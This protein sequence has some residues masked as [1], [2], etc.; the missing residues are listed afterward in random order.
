[1]ALIGTLVSFANIFLTTGMGTGVSVSSGVFSLVGDI[2]TRSE[3]YAVRV[4]DVMDEG[5]RDDL[6]K[7]GGIDAG[8]L[9]AESDERE[10]S[11]PRTA[12]H[13]NL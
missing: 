1:L 13:G 12:Q 8:E 7:R 9:R 2:E 3:A 10:T 5:D 6:L 11:G 4:L